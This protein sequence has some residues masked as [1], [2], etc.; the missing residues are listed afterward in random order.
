MKITKNTLKQIIKEEL[1][2]M[3]EQEP[4]G[5]SGTYNFVVRSGD[6]TMNAV[7]YITNVPV[8]ML[9]TSDYDDTVANRPDYVEPARLLRLSPEA[10][11]QIMGRSRS[12]YFYDARIKEIPETVQVDATFD[13]RTGK[14]LEARVPKLIDASS[15]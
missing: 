7:A 3:Q 1:E 2:A 12:G 15:M 10:F 6:R 13:L 4:G 5:L 11:E 14:M 8:S 9:D